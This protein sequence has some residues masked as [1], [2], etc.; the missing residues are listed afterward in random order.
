MAGNTEEALRRIHENKRTKSKI[1]DLSGLGLTELPDELWDCVWVEE[2]GLGHW[3]SWNEE[4]Q[5]WAW[6][7][8]DGKIANRLTNLPSTLSNFTKLTRL[9][10]DYKQLRDISVLS[11][12]VNLTKLSLL[13]SGIKD[14]SDLNT[15]VNLTNLDLSYTQ[16]SDISTLST[17]V[18]LTN[19]SLSGSGIKDIGA[20]STLV[21]LT[22]LSLSGSGI[23]DIGA[24][25]TL[26]NLTNLSLSGS[27][28]KD[29]G[30]LS[31]LVNLT[32]LSLSGSGIK[33][34]GALSSLVNLTNLN[35][36]HTQIS[37]I[38]ALS[39]LSRLNRVELELDQVVD[40]SILKN[41][42]YL[43]HLAL[44]S[45]SSHHY[46][47]HIHNKRSFRLISKQID[48]ISVLSNLV[49]LSTLELHTND[50]RDIST[51]SSL[52]NLTDLSLSGSG[53]NDIS[54]LSNLVNLTKLT[55][56]GSEINDISALSNLV[57]LTNLTLSDSEINDISAL[58]NLV[59]LT[60]LTL[61]GSEIKDIS[62][63]SGLVNL[64][65]LSLWNN[66][67]SDI[68]ALSTLVNLT[69]LSLSGSGIK[70]VSTL[71]N[72][73][74]LTDLSLSGSGIKDISALSNLVN[75]A[76]F[77]LGGTQVSDI[78]SLSNLNHLNRVE[79][80]LDQVVDISILKNY[81]Y[82]DHLALISV[83]NH[84]LPHDPHRRSFMLIAKQIDDIS[85]LSN[86]VNLSTL[87]LHTNHL[88][89]ISPL[90]SLVNLNKLS[91]EGSEFN[92][93]AG[94][95]SLLNLTNL[96]LADAQISDISELGSLVNLTNLY[97]RGEQL[98][99]INPLSSLVNLT[100]LTLAGA[101]ISDI[102]VLG[103]LINLTK[104]NL[105]G[106]QLM[107]INP[108]S[109]LVNLTELTLSG[110][111]ISDISVLGN[112]INLTKLYLSGE[113]L[114][115]ISP[116]N[117]LVNLA[118][119]DLGGTSVSD[120]SAL[121]SLV[122]LIYLNLSETNVIDISHLKSLVNLAILDLSYTS[123]S[124]ISA[125]SSLV[126]LVNLDLSETNVI[127]INSLS[128]LINLADL[129]LS[130]TNV[131]DI[132]PLGH[133]VN[134]ADLILIKTKLSDISILNSL[135]KLTTL[136]LSESAV[137][138]FPFEIL[139]L[140]K[141]ENLDLQNTHCLNLPPELTHED[142][143]LPD[144]RNYYAE[145]QK[146]AYTAYD[147]KLIT[148]G[149]GRVGKTSVLKAL[150]Q[151]EAFNPQ[152]DSTHGIQLFTTALPLPQKPEP[153]K[154]KLWDFGGQELYHA[155]HRIFMKSRAL[156]LLVW[157]PHTEQ[158]PGED[159]ITIDGQTYI[160]RNYPLSYWLGNIR[161]LS[162]HAKIIVVC[163]KSD[164]GQERFP[165]QLS[166]LQ[167]KY[168]I[169]SF[170]SVSARTGYG[171]S[172][173]HQRIEYLLEQMPEVGMQMPVSWKQVQDQL[174]AITDQPFIPMEQ[175]L[176]ICATEGLSE[177]S[178][179]TVLRFLHHSGFLFWHEQYLQ[180]QIILDQKWALGA[181]YQLLDRNSWYKLL[182]GNGLRKRSD[183]SLCWKEY[184][185]A[186][187]QVFLEM[188]QSCEL[189]LEIGD[190]KEKDPT[191][192][193]PEFLPDHPATAV[194]Y[195]WDAAT[196]T[197]F[198]FRFQHHFFHAALIQRFIARSAKLAESYDLLWRT[199]LLLKVEG[200][201]ARIQVYPEEGRIEMQV[202]GT[203]SAELIERLKNEI[204]GIQETEGDSGFLLSLSGQ[205]EE[206]VTLEQIQQHL[207]KGK[208]HIASTTGEI[209]ELAPFR[210]LIHTPSQEEE[211][212][213]ALPMDLKSLAD[214]Q[215]GAQL[216]KATTA[217]NLAEFKFT[218]KRKIIEGI[219]VA[220]TYLFEHLQPNSAAQD[221]LILLQGQWSSF[222]RSNRIGTLNHDNTQ[223]SE[224][225]IR[226]RIMSLINSLK[227]QDLKP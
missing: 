198:H 132:N 167:E 145:L 183:L 8:N 165:D 219:E 212:D 93:I 175:Y 98:R 163:N 187:V 27:G 213:E 36:S 51:L 79:L 14:I 131:I 181:I 70:D 116:L 97:L 185:P 41:F 207:K 117:S 144:L 147:A 84:H 206:W 72:L 134:L 5:D 217:F 103:S 168:K 214:L 154:L 196:S 157:D 47:P 58:S 123:V 125:L 121:S 199:G 57:N 75:L 42:A 146:N 1:L 109:S 218:A 223:L 159:P 150:F 195:T 34:I 202:R 77:T 204:A 107:D 86:L 30:A 2:L 176:H 133:L 164:D 197:V 227:E 122:N 142:N 177:D 83:L 35:L 62:T 104:L 222:S 105:S 6:Y 32:N 33:D 55:L 120:I 108:L 191:Y 71:S 102:S 215:S 182:K 54:A 66:A 81:T 64:T 4:K 178:A 63:L 95:S 188:M 91:L 160:F 224:N 220:M 37:D 88:R 45:D 171:L 49:N 7:Y 60:N 25:S 29:I 162:T 26:V 10:L 110:A 106:E 136:N 78:S 76:N 114:S 149:N 113:Q 130:K 16:I 92:D 43:D 100:E 128:G 190:D 112:L 192:L 94:L 169:D 115:N 21:N 119:L 111:Q 59:S 203:N 200:T 48:D 158:K 20:L 138:Y 209:L 179:I 208:S 118:N 172:T 127:D 189:A 52:V 137:P 50:L 126:N 80:K 24:L 152:E 205:E 173:L 90:R 9:L 12:L 67:I 13:G 99:D 3:Y 101:Q 153:A 148:V 46:S 28:I 221:E 15:L 225:Q 186:Q 124:D 180:D 22:N 38:S 23:K 129:I 11:S 193:I 135:K 174:A 82:L 18:N 56:S 89:D 226:E 194:A 210:H 73:V 161:A 151:I 184:T 166:A 53:I 216:L 139:F 85:V 96:T 87:E 31:T 211:E 156:Y 74:N 143:A 69:D 155:T 39:S 140:P 201:M 68:S 65:T 19:L 17:L 44:I 141:L 170:I 61:S 40:I